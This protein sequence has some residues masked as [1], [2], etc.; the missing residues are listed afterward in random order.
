[1]SSLKTGVNINVR[2]KFNVEQCAKSCRK[3]IEIA[4]I[5]C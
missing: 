2:N 1:M 5:S 3:T 4:Q